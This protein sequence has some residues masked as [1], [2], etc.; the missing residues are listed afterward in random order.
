M[1]ACF[2]AAIDFGDAAVVAS[3]AAQVEQYRRIK[4]LF[5]ADFYPLTPYSTEAKTWMA[6]Q[7]NRPETGEGMVQAFR[8]AESSCKVARFKLHG[9]DSAALYSLNNFDVPGTIEMTGRELTESGLSV[10][11]K[12]QPGSVVITYKKAK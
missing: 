3:V 11:I 7:F 10:A 8:R 4:H 2:T 9:L 5:Q 1:G 12:Q 6:W